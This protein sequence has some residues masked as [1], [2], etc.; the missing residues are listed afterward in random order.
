[1]GCSITISQAFFPIKSTS[2]RLNMRSVRC[3]LLMGTLAAAQAANSEVHCVT[4]MGPKPVSPVG[5]A[6]AESTSTASLPD[7]TTTTAVTETLTAAPITETETTTLEV[8]TTTTENTVTDTYTSTSTE[9]ET[10]T[11][12]TTSTATETST[13]NEVVTSTSTTVIGAA[14]TF[15]PIADTANGYPARKRDSH[16]RHCHKATVPK[17][18]QYPTSIVG[19][20]SGAAQ[21]SPSDGACSLGEGTQYPTEV[22]CSVTTTVQQTLTQTETSSETV[23]PAPA[24]ETTTSTV[25]STSTEVPRASTTQIITETTTATETATATTTTTETTTSTTTETAMATEYAGCGPNNIFETYQG[26]PITNVFNNGNGQLTGAT[27]LDYVIGVSSAVQCCV[28]CLKKEGCTGSIYPKGSTACYLMHNRDRTC[29]SQS[30]NQALFVTS[31][32]G[33][34]YAI[35]NGLCGYQEYRAQQA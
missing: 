12:T 18:S 27:I 22:Q 3:I 6:T 2:Q 29:A 9:T 19:T 17:P 35:S 28:A 23:T 4:A 30:A 7:V 32:A 34:G 13:V 24:T 26:R 10:S 20:Y 11:T 5:T 21:P 16:R 31:N 33:T 25:T 8:T 14:S 1:M 15:V